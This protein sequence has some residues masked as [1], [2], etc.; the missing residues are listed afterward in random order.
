MEVVARFAKPELRL[1][2]HLGHFQEKLIRRDDCRGQEDYCL[3]LDLLLG[4]RAEQPA[5]QRNSPKHRHT[6]F[7]ELRR[8]LDHAPDDD[9]HAILHN[10]C[11]RRLGLLYNRYAQH[12]FLF[13]AG[14][15]VPALDRA[16]LRLDIHGD[17]II[18]VDFRRYRQYSAHFL[19]LIRYSYNI[20]CSALVRD[21]PVRLAGNHLDAGF[22]A[23]H[24]GNMR[25]RDDL[26]VANR[27]Q[28]IDQQCQVASAGDGLVTQ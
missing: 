2:S 18:V 9:R 11:R 23:V 19:P 27:L 15:I 3:R 8:T 28:R 20:R 21:F 12:A 22:L 13:L 7:I 5:D 16:D 6:R 26:R 4:S 25:V 10:H 24:H 14:I 17:V 1:F